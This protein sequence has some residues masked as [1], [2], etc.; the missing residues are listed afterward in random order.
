MD[1]KRKID[2]HFKYVE[3]LPTTQLERRVIR[4]QDAVDVHWIEYIDQEII[5]NNVRDWQGLEEL[6]VRRIDEIF[7]VMKRMMTAMNMKQGEGECLLSFMS[8]LKI[9]QD[10]VEWEMWPDERKK[11]ADLFQRITDDKLKDE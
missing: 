6:M 1:W 9:A 2:T 3:R 8:R 7:P 4:L 10:S 11:A 5:A